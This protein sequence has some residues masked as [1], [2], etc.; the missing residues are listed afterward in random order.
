MIGNYYSAEQRWSDYKA[1]DA[2]GVGQGVYVVGSINKFTI[3]AQAYGQERG[4]ANAT[5]SVYLGEIIPSG[6]ANYKAAYV[7]TFTWKEN[8]P[9]NR[10][11]PVGLFVLVVMKIKSQKR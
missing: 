5:S 11:M 7:L 9:S 6:I 1:S 4:I 10:L 2:Q 8:Y 3:Y